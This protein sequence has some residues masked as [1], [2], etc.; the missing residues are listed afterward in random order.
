MVLGLLVQPAR[1]GRNCR[2]LVLR[3][4][5]PISV[6]CTTTSYSV[7]TKYQDKV[8][9]MVID[10]KGTG[11]MTSLYRIREWWCIFLCVPCATI[12]YSLL[13][14]ENT[15]NV[16]KYFWLAQGPRSLPL[17]TK[18]SSQQTYEGNLKATVNNRWRTFS[19]PRA[20]NQNPRAAKHPVFAATAVFNAQQG[21]VTK[22]ASSTPI[23]A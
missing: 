10:A 11:T 9:E 21:H 16:S 19:I 18:W 14:I 15:W 8:P 17:T 12:R 1:Q 23:K 7:L 3:Y 5:V 6:P 4:H 2:P 20:T 22:K 13:S